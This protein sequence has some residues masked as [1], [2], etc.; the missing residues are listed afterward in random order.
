MVIAF[1]FPVIVGMM[2]YVGLTGDASY[3]HI[4]DVLQTWWGALA[5][6]LI[7]FGASFHCMHRILFSL[8]D[9]KFRPGRVGKVACYGIAASLSAAAAIG[10]AM[11]LF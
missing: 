8:H 2:I 3:F 6:F 7:V 11:V 10:I 1:A 5:V 9:L 4:S